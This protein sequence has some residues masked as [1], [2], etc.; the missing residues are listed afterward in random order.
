MEMKILKKFNSNSKTYVQ[1]LEWEHLIPIIP[2]HLISM[3]AIPIPIIAFPCAKHGLR[4]QEVRVAKHAKISG[5][6]V[7]GIFKNLP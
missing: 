6:Y 2:G 5:I 3:Y 7:V 4:S 1:T